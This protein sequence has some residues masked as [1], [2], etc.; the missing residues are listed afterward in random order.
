MQGFTPIVQGSTQ[1]FFVV[2]DPIAQV[3]APVVFNRIFA[4]YGVDAVAVPAQTSAARLEGFV[5]EALALGNTGGLMVSV[6]HKIALAGQVD[7]LD[8]VARVA[9]SLN[10]VRRNADQSTEGALFDGAGFVGALRHHGIDVSG[11]KVLLVGAGGAGLAIAAALATLPIGRLDVHDASPERADQLLARVGPLAD[12]PVA[13]AARPLGSAAD[14]VIQATPLGMKEADPLPL[15]PGALR[16]GTVVFDILMM[17]QPTPLMRACAEAGLVA[18]PGHEM[19]LQ[20]VP[21]YLEFFRMPEIAQALRE[22]DSLPMRQLRA[23]I[24]G[25]PVV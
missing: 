4:A 25:L 1:V 14:L 11:R 9:G 16:A 2:A 5:H 24:H 18:F 8:P 22:P 17:R 10:A 13:L 7:R 15:D 6:P 20:Q 12:F 23:T 19:L 3:K 21:A